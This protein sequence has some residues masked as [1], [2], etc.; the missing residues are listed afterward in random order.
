MKLKKREIAL[1]IVLAIVII[2]AGIVIFVTLREYS[3]GEKIYLKFQEYVFLPEETPA[4]P[5][6]SGETAGIPETP[7][8]QEE[9]RVDDPVDV[10]TPVDTGP[11]VVDFAGLQAVNSDVL[12]WIYSAGTP[13]N[14][15]VV[16]G[17]TNEEYLYR[18]VDGTVNKCGS[19]FLDCGNDKEFQDANSIIHGH[20]MNNGSMF[21]EL[22]KYA[23]QEYYDQHSRIWL[24][25][26][27]QTYSI[28]IFAAFVTEA[29][30]EVWRQNFPSEEEF[31][32]WKSNMARKSFFTSKVFP[33]VGEKVV[34]LSTCSYEFDNAHFV[35]IGV[36]R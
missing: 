27:S 31:T 15:P 16:Q 22:K 7:A 24:V 4:V 25:T 5:P 20:N 8:P 26:P 34:T 14:Y 13:I 28:E 33:A 30:S 19:I 36:L 9:N 18:M 3:E 2:A 21:S 23:K 10:S 32:T 35:V 29:D 11:P 12:G 1:I 6:S 17:D